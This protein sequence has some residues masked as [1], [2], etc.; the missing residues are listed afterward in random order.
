MRIL[1]AGTL[2]LEPFSAGIAWDWIQ[3]A[4]GLERMGHEVYLVEEAMAAAIGAGPPESSRSASG[5][6][7]A[8]RIR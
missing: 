8:L 2:T 1:V 6:V 4:L 3:I 7:A 5:T